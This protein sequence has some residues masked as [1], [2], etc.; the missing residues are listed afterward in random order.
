MSKQRGDWRL[1]HLGCRGGRRALD[2]WGRGGEELVRGRL[3]RNRGVP[4]P[5]G[6]TSIKPWRIRESVPEGEA[7]P[8]RGVGWGLTQVGAARAQQSAGQGAW[9][10]P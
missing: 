6:V 1:E 8:A 4:S 3:G 5:R 10:S 2:R 9:P 7:Q